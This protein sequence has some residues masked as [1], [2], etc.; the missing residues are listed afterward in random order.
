VV[1]FR[2]E[3]SFHCYLDGLLLADN[4]GIPKLGERFGC[5]PVPVWGGVAVDEVISEVNA[6]G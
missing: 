3:H 1:L 5:M 6:V 2:V 4:D